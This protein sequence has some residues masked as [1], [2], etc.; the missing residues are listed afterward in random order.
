MEFLFSYGTLQQRNVQMANFGREL[1]GF[2][3]FLPKYVVEEINI[4]DEVVIRKSGKSVHPILRFTGN[5]EDR[6]LGTVFEITRKELSQADNYETDQ[7]QRIS[8]V[9]ESGRTCWIYA[10]KNDNT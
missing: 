6:V 8:A 5:T 1:S 4:I 2:R 3:D 9:L 10:A 7:Y